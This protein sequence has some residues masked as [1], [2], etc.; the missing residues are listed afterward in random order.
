MIWNVLSQVPNPVFLWNVFPLHP[1]AD[2][3]PFSNQ[4]HNS[5]ERI[6]GEELLELIIHL[7]QPKRIIAI[8]NDAETSAMKTFKKEN[9]IKV[10]HPSYG[11]QNIFLAQMRSLYNAH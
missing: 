1:F 2:G 11:G 5:K 4:A 3:D 7:L 8:G 6:A 9:I 10:R